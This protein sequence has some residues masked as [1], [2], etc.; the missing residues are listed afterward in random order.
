MLATIRSYSLVG[1]DM[2]TNRAQMYSAVNDKL[3]NQ[4]ISYLE[5]GVWKGDS[6]RAWTT[7]NTNPLTHF[8][9]FDSFEGLPEDWIKGFGRA[10]KKG[11]FGLDGAVPSISDSRVTLING[12][13]QDTLQSF[14]DIT[15]LSH[16]IVV[17][18]DSDLHSS[19]LYTLCMLNPILQPG[20]IIIFD[21]YS[22]PANEYL[23]WE[24]YKH[25]FMRKAECIAMSDRWTQV[26]FMLT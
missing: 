4:S 23:A 6:L 18:N 2:F 19:T 3:S 7:I 17:N 21:E 20:D 10:T 25:A 22:S 24:E 13:F 26:A 15:Q 11:Q 8:Y 12:W 14:L 1:V 5:F 16:P 9:G